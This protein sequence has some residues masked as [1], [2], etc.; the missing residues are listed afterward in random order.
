[1]QAKDFKG[2]LRAFWFDG[3]RELRDD[4][5]SLSVGGILSY[6]TQEFY[7]LSGLVSFFSSN[8][9]SSLNDM[10]DAGATSNLQ[11][12]GSS[13][14]VLGEAALKYRYE[15]TVIKYGRQRINT[16]LVNDYYNRMLPNSFEGL[17]IENNS[18]DKTKIQAAYITGWKYKNAEEFISPTHNY[19]FDRDIALLGVSSTTGI[20]K[21]TIF[22]YYIADVMNAVY[23]ESRADKLL[24]DA[25][26][27]NLSCGVQ[28]LQEDSVGDSLLGLSKTYLVGLKVGLHYED[29]TL[30]GMMTKV[31]D[32]TLLGTGNDYSKMGWSSF[33]TY[34]DIQVD[35]ES[36]NA[37]AFAFGG[38]LKRKINKNFEASIKYIHINQDDSK[39]SDSQS[40][41]TN[42]RP[43][44]NEYNID[45]T[46]KA[47]KMFKLRT[48]FAYIDYD[49]KSTQLYKDKAYDEFNTRIIVDYFF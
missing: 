43:D 18:F 5:T 15:N 48:R 8:G 40:L 42:P 7:N 11:N 36:E 6:Q 32:E 21:I 45:A 39:Q 24:L 17:S 16:P 26:K 46:Y 2:N 22:D 33:I 34:T 29:W 47:T 13:I 3:Q 30:Q 38:S 9:I 4:R 35:G 14:N 44:S 23:F 20:F 25:R 28:Y 19:G 41:T 10:P 31:G 1:M 49:S 37:G 27:W 12:D